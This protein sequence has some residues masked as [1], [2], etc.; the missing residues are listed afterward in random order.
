MPGFF[1][2]TK[3]ESR[4]IFI[5]SNKHHH[6]PATSL[7]QTPRTHRNFRKAL[8]KTSGSRRFHIQQASHC[9]QSDKIFLP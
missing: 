1:S 3:K 5:A 8:L 7:N 4:F 9:Q 2:I 6:L